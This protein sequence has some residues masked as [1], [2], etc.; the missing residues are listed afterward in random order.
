MPIYLDADACPVK[1][2]SYKVARRH[3]VKVYVVTNNPI[4][5][6]DDPLIE[7][8]VVRGGFDAADNWIAEQITPA[9]V[10]VTSDIPLA[11]RCLKAGARVI[12]P[13]GNEWTDDTIHDALATRALLDMLR[14]GGNF[15]GGPS[16]FSPADRSR[17]LSRLDNI[18]V[19]LRKKR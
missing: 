11:E 3:G 14:Q 6:P 10:A 7:L 2:E 5:V 19:A 8:V 13:K 9:D 15:T 1:D 16:P 4:R 18:L 12:G 17:F